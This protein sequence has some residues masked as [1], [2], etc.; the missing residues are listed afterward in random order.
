MPLAKAPTL[1]Q[2]VQRVPPQ[3]GHDFMCKEIHYVG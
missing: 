3:R 2:L 1:S